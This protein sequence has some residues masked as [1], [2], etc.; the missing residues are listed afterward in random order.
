MTLFYYHCSMSGLP[1]LN[2][3]QFDFKAN[4]G[5]FYANDFAEH[6]RTY[7]AS[8]TKPHKH[9]FYLI[10]LFTEGKGIHEVDFN[11]YTIERGALFL[12][13]PGQTHHW[14]FTERAEGYIFF[15]SA[16][17]YR[18]LFPNKNIDDYPAFYSAYN[19]PLLLLNEDAI[20][21]Y[22]ERFHMVHQ[23]YKNDGLMKYRKLGLLVDLL[24]IDI[25]RLYAKDNNS[26]DR[27]I[28]KKM[29]WFIKLE[30]LIDKEFKSKKSPSDYADS[31]NISVKHL[32]KIVMQT[33]GKTT[34]DLIH[35][36]IILEA[37]RML[38]H[39]KFTVQEIAFKLGYDDVSY[40]SRFFK[41][42]CGMSPTDFSKSYD[43]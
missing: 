26:N 30:H 32:N 21:S 28:E 12:L 27:F 15:H 24:Y 41:K 20:T 18:L 31:L 22:E 4:D 3:K 38:T 17:F 19:S 29:E 16:E 33:I 43:E 35:Q 10:V 42:K 37:K 9:D 1:V 13:T 14:E 5:N 36:R 11:S 6:L 8:I 39:G 25:A 40:F 7:H 34:S 2:I 23:E